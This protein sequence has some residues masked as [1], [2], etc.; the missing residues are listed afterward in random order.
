MCVCRDFR[1]LKHLR[2]YY[3]NQEIRNF[4]SK[5]YYRED[6]N[7]Q[8]PL[9]F[10]N[11]LVWKLVEWCIFLY[12][13]S[14]KQDN[15]ISFTVEQSTGFVKLTGLALDL[16]D[17]LV[18]SESGCSLSRPKQTAIAEHAHMPEREREKEREREREIL[19]YLLCLHFGPNTTDKGYVAMLWM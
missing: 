12:K 10:C 1:N 4:E 3:S 2:G 8:E 19:S 6:R 18:F 5:T 9:S 15:S 11:C 16:I 7:S 17:L 14:A 13:L